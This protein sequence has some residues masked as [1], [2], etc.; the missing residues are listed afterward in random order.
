M[1]KYVLSFD[2]LPGKAEEFW[3]FMEQEA[4]PFWR[5]FPD[6]GSFEVYST[7]GGNGLYEA[8]IE[9]PNYETFERVRTDLAWNDMS[10]SFMSLV[11]NL[12]RKFL[13]DERKFK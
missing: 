11:D 6:V 10:H 4:V 8:Q 13:T 9:M 5:K 3:R 2:I 1:I 12:H 7:I